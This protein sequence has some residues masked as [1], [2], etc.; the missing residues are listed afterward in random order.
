[1][2]KMMMKMSTKMRMKKR[3]KRMKVLKMTTYQAALNKA[4]F[5]PD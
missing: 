5:L 2:M 1:M 3:K 4:T